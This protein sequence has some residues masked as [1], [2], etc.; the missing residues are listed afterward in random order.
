M[1][2]LQA[3]DKQMFINCLGIHNT[4]HCL[5]DT[6]V[7]EFEVP[8]KVNSSTVRDMYKGESF[9]ANVPA[10]E[11]VIKRRLLGGPCIVSYVE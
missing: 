7:K 3:A 9:A 8:T 1:M 11:G 2:K 10:F 4:W 5:L 6:L